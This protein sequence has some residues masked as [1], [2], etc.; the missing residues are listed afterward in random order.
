[1]AAIERVVVPVDFSGNTDKL[2]QYG[3]SVADELDAEVLFL[4]VINDFQGYDMMLVHPSF[5]GITKDLEQQ[6]EERMAS[7]LKEHAKR[8]RGVRGEVVVGDA[9]SEIIGYARLEKA[10][11]II[12]GTHG[13]KG[14]DKVLIGS[15][16]D[17]VIKKAPCPVLVYNPYS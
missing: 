6:A 14:L 7:L 8:K 1:M 3:V 16:A 17:R 5:L 2:V 11:M 13:V 9:A 12:I 4:H 15:T 10:D